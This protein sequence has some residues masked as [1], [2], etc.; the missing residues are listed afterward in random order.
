MPIILLSFVTYS[1][2]QLKVMHSGRVSMENNLS[3]VPDTVS[4]TVPAIK[5]AST[6]LFQ[7]S[8]YGIYSKVWY[9]KNPAG[10]HFSFG[11]RAIAVYGSSEDNLIPLNHT[12][13]PPFNAGVA[14]TSDKG[15]GV[16]GAIKDTF[17]IF[18]P[19]S[20][21][22]YFM[23]NT[24]VIGTL[25]YTSLT[26][27]SDACTKHDITYLNDNTIGSIMQLKPLSFYYNTDDKLFNAAD[28]ESPA[29]KQMHYGFIAQE[30]QEVLPDIV[31]MGQ[32]SLLSIN[33]IEL[34][35]LLVQTIQ[36]QEG[37]IDE[38]ER[39]IAKLSSHTSTNKAPQNIENDSMASQAILYQNTP[40]PF[41][42][43]TR[44]AYDLPLN[45]HEATLYIY[46]VNGLQLESYPIRAFGANSITISGG[47]LSAGIYLYSLV[48]DGH[49]IDTKR[50][51]L[52][53]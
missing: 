15:V 35:P 36:N 26:Q 41:A 38:L 33:Y 6:A 46:D 23:G 3:V 5:I 1:A 30:L 25:T 47:H 20:Y 39:K 28:V 16:Y 50:M 22:G 21:A 52:T 49:V 13:T 4:D 37:R 10:P 32:D 19:G 7:K 18:N 53:K 40:N 43:D 27:T 14:G 12:S 8:A 17:P 44:I 9:Q 51:I 2:A 24:K 31:Y 42:Q 34:I 45:T 11:N 48:A 29:A